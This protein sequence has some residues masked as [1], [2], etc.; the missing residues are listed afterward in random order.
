MVGSAF[1]TFGSSVLFSKKH[2]FDQLIISSNKPVVERKMNSDRIKT[3][4]FG[5]EIKKNDSLEM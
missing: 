3:N 5:K 1:R 2:F 4:H